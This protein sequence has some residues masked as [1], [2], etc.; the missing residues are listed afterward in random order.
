MYFGPTMISWSANAATAALQQA[1]SL[2][3]QLPSR[4]N[5]TTRGGEAEGHAFW[6]QNAKLLEDARLELGPL[7]PQL[8]DLEAHAADFISPALRDAVEACERQATAGEAVDESVLRKLLQPAGAPNVWRLTV[9]NPT[10]CNLLS[11]HISS[12]FQGIHTGSSFVLAA[13]QPM[14]GCGVCI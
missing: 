9:F 6:E 3:A 7:H 8:Y 13:S 2:A 14:R 4:L 12:D 11:R 1:R 5:A 10:F